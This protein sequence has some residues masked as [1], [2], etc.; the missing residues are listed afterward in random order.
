MPTAVQVHLTLAASN[1]R[2]STVGAV[3]LATDEH[4]GEEVVVASARTQRVQVD[5]ALGIAGKDEGA[6]RIPATQRLPSDLLPL[7]KARDVPRLPQLRAGGRRASRFVLTRPSLL[8]Q[9]RWQLSD[10]LHASGSSSSK[11]SPRQNRCVTSEIAKTPCQ[12]GS[13]G[14]RSI[15]LIIPRSAVRS[16]PPPSFPSADRI[17]RCGHEWLE[18]MR[19][20]G[21]IAPA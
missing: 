3:T 4:P 9:Y 6:A 21:E 8:G 1:S 13:S 2:H 18:Q 5:S 7:R 19:R 16:S 15:P 20:S 11:R 12:S 17:C 10:D 14:S